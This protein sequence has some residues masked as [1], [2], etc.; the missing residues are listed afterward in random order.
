MILFKNGTYAGQGDSY[1]WF[2]RPS[3]K[4]VDA[5]TTLPTA[6]TPSGNRAVIETINT[7]VNGVLAKYGVTLD[8]NG[9]LTGFQQLNN[10]STGSFIINADYFS[11]VKP[12]G[13][14]SLTWS[15]GAL[16]VN[17]GT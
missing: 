5:G 11:I 13:G 16:R 3:I 12:G 4:E 17:D 2:C 9:Y 7:S 8:V 14:A 6:Y 10:G 15:S 1:A